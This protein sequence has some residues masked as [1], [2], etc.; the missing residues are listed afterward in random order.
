[1][2]WCRS[3][4]VRKLSDRMNRCSPSIGNF[5]QI[6]CKIRGFHDIYP[7]KD[8]CTMYMCRWLAWWFCQRGLFSSMSL[9]LDMQWRQWCKPNVFCVRGEK[10]IVLVF[11]VKYI[12]HNCCY[13]CY[14]QRWIDLHCWLQ[15]KS[16][17][18]SGCWRFTYSYSYVLLSFV[19]LVLHQWR[20]IHRHSQRCGPYTTTAQW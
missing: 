3:I 2:E 16:L 6:V 15:F 19:W 20:C 8:N 5:G 10:K 12:C 18:Q 1:M 14:C 7:H 17:C 9:R 11:N 4:C 13:L